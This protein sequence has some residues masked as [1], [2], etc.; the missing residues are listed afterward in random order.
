MKFKAQ[1]NLLVR[2]RNT[3]PVRYAKFNDKGFYET[4]DA[5]EIERLKARF[6]EVK[7]KKKEGSK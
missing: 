7:P 2:F 5:F 6:E 3:K 4:T 1:P